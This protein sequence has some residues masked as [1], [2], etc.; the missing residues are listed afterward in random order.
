M[1]GILLID[2]NADFSANK[3][4]VLRI[5][6]TITANLKALYEL[7]SDAKTALYNIATNKASGT[8]LAQ[9]AYSNTATTFTGKQI[10]LPNILSNNGENT[11]A[12]IIKVKP[13]GA[14]TDLAFGR[15]TAAPTVDGADYVLSGARTVTASFG[16][17]TSSTGG[18]F[19][20]TIRPTLAFDSS[21]DNT[22][23]LVIATFKSQVGG[24]IYHPKTGQTNTV[25]IGANEYFYIKQDAADGG[26]NFTGR[27]TDPQQSVAM[28]AQWDRVLTQSEIAQFYNE[29]KTQYARIGLTI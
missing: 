16:G 15:F 22:Y 3:V 26:I 18:A 14:A 11:I 25:K 29:M 13:D 4:A 17:F 2:K 28:Y 12:F 7:R 8:Q 9:P 23:Q 19:I 10:S 5:A 24:S 1:M 27:S 6:T 20:E 21:Y